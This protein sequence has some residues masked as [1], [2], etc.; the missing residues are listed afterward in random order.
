MTDAPGA[1]P[2]PVH[3]IVL[4]WKYVLTESLMTA[5]SDGLLFL[6]YFVSIVNLS[7]FSL[8]ACR[9]FNPKAFAKLRQ[10]FHSTKFFETFF[11]LFLASFVPSG[12][13]PLYVNELG[14]ILY[15]WI[16]A[17][18]L[19]PDVLCWLMPSKAT[20]KLTPLSFSCKLFI[21]YIV[22]IFVNNIINTLT[23]IVLYDT[24]SPSRKF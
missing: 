23:G 24:L 14:S 17:P 9:F 20:A 6:Y 8:S 4:D 7:M 18:R 10:L 22:L 15:R 21:N 1:W 5:F 13:I 12:D 3:F 16:V 2:R 19:C 11:E